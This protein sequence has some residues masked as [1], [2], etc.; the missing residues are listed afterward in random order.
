MKT[1]IKTYLDS[2]KILWK[3]KLLIIVPIFNVFLAIFV[4]RIYRN[5][6]GLPGFLAN[7]FFLAVEV[8]IELL[9]IATI[10][11][12]RNVSLVSPSTWDIA[13]KYFWRVVGIKVGSLFAV[14][15]I[16]SPLCFFLFLLLVAELN[17]IFSLLLVF[18]FFIYM[19]FYFGVNL[20]GIRILVSQDK[21]I[22]ESMWA[23]FQE[24][25]KNTSYYFGFMTIS[26]FLFF[27][28]LIVS[29][30]MS[31]VQTGFTMF[32]VPF[33]PYDVFYDNY[34]QVIK[35]LYDKNVFATF[36]VFF[37]YFMNPIFI[38]AITLIFVN[39]P[40]LHTTIV[41]LQSEIAN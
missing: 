23:G 8:I 32:S 33:V 34:L 15:T 12:D 20:L 25:R 2:L 1:A 31:L 14:L 6:P 5:Y 28:P 21:K 10:F 11:K 40:S 22:G 37:G 35:T 41:N 9:I 18:A 27:L 26:F 7:I 30:L 4:L 36:F 3:Y 29:N 38:S 39:S 17:I 13:I 24:L 16:I 19:V